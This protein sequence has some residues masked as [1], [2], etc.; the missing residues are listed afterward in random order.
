MSAP[1]AEHLDEAG[2]A[3]LVEEA[4]IAER[5]S[6]F[7]LSS[8][9]WQLVRAWR[10]AG[11]PASTVV[12]AVRETFERRRSRGAAGKINSISYCAGAVEELWEME[13][14]GLVGRARREHDEPPPDIGARLDALTA[15]LRSLAHA[16][17]A[18]AD[19][20]S[21]RKGIAKALSK[22]EALPRDGSFEEVEERLSRI[23]ASLVKA[24]VPA[25][26]LPSSADVSAE[27]EGSLGDAS[28]LLPAVVTRMRTALTRRALRRRLGLPPLTLLGP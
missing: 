23:E 12:R 13:R 26:D 28:G 10:E 1:P 14:R 2:Y 18:G 21:L 6:P 19:P 11:I 4:F 3:T 27:V 15:A 17:P 22:I 9:D 7:L 20:G 5:G 8:K 25:L 24:L 16:A